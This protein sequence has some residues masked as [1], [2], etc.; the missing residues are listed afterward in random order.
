[1][2]R[3]QAQYDSNLKSESII[4]QDED[5]RRLRVR[6]LFQ[7][8]VN[9]DLQD[10][11]SIEDDR[12]YALEVARADL[13]AQLDKAETDAHHSQAELRAKGKEIETLKVSTSL[14]SCR[15]YL[16]ILDGAYIHER[17]VEGLEQTP[18]REIR[19]GERAGKHEARTRPSTGPS[20]VSAKYTRRKAISE[21]GRASCRERVF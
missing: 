15:G 19:A 8:D 17:A 12:V 2:Q 9:D 10:Q 11:L 1:M 14:I 6:L 21:I 16:M 4:H 3:L 7:E 5:L 20:D 18:S 13:Q